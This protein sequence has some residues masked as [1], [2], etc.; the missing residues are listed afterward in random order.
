MPNPTTQAKIDALYS[1]YSSE[2]AMDNFSVEQMDAL[3]YAMAVMD[4][5]D[6]YKGIMNRATKLER[7]AK[8]L[9]SIGLA[10]LITSGLFA[11]FVN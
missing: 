6:E 2:Y 9:F 8:S 5:D 1:I 10:L 11:V 7:H 4:L 3:E